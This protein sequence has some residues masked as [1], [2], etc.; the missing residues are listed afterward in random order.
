[1]TRGGPLVVAA[2]A[3]ALACRV[4]FAFLYWH[5][6]PLTRDEREYLDLAQQA[7]TGRGLHYP[8]T[9]AERFSRA[10]LYPLFVAGVLRASGGERTAVTS[11]PAAPTA[12]RAGCVR[13]RAGGP[14]G[15]A[16]PP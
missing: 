12:S 4:G 6:K 10:P 15:A 7:A 16:G 8:D 13:C 9:G 1:M 3:V 11:T 2:L 14:R 5:D